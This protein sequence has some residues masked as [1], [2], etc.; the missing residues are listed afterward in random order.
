MEWLIKA[1]GSCGELI[2]GT[3]NN[4]PF[5]I[6]CP[7][8]MYTTV[9][10]SKNSNCLTG[11]GEKAQLA[12]RRTLEF[13][14]T[15]NINCG[16]TLKCE[17][18]SG[19]GMASSSADI[20]AVCQ[21]TALAAS[22]RCLTTEEIAALAAAIEPTD[23]IFYD[24][25]VMFNHITGEC[26]QKLGQPPPLNIA[27]FDVGG[28][29]DTINFNRRTDLA[30]LNQQKEPQ[31]VQACQLLLA[32][33]KEQRPDL[34]GRA[35]TIS[36]VANQMILAKRQLPLLKKIARQ[37]GALGINTAHSGTVVG[38][39]FAVNDI[40]RCDY[41]IKQVLEQCGNVKFIGQA[42]L[43]GGGLIIEEVKHAET[44]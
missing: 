17:L 15:D 43:I 25:I 40:D 14:Q 13:L 28:E 5:L 18:P 35:A 11:L 6:T 4:V 23:G 2:Q 37:S 22:G 12:R 7:I 38:F 19:K 42:S 20:A 33:I 1:P 8:N 31:I 9:Y 16:M 44:V 21:L 26:L 34:I 36:A 41:S 39:L 32:G 30:A 24:G 10:T 29:V 3:I 27:V